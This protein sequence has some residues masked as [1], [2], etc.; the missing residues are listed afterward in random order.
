MTFLELG[1]GLLFSAILLTVDLLLQRRRA[2]PPVSSGRRVWAGSILTLAYFCGVLAFV[3][4]ASSFEHIGITSRNL[5]GLIVA[6][7]IGSVAT[8]WS[9]KLLFKVRIGTLV[10]LL[11]IGLSAALVSGTAPIWGH[12]LLVLNHGL[13]FSPFWFT[14]LVIGETGYAW[15]WGRAAAGA[16]QT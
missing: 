9:L 13:F 8:Y 10:S 12:K 15:V 2:S 11:L 16:L 5:L 4:V 6:A 14:L 7:I 3:G 1:A